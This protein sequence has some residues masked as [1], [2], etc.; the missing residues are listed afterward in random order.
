MFEATTQT[1]TRQAIL[2][3]HEARGDAFRHLIAWLIGP[4]KVKGPRPVGQGPEIQGC[5]A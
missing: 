4:R 1:E 3:A 5:R 2:A